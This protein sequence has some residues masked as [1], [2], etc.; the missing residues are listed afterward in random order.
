MTVDAQRVVAIMEELTEKLTY[1]SVVTRQ[2]VMVKR[3]KMTV[4]EERAR[5][6]LLERY[7]QQEKAAS[8]RRTELEKQLTL[9]RTEREK[10]SN[11]SCETVVKLK[12][13]LQ[14]VHDFTEQRLAQ[15]HEQYRK[16][17]AEHTRNF[18]VR[19]SELVARMNQQQKHN[20][21]VFSRGKQETDT[22]KS[23]TKIAEKDLERIIETYDREMMEKNAKAREVAEANATK[24][25]LVVNL[26]KQLQVIN[27][28]ND[29]IRQEY[30]IEKVR[31]SIIDRQLQ[32]LAAAATLLQA[33]WRG[34]RQREEY[35]AMKKNARNKRGWKGKKN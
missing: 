29:R 4:E 34:I 12:A 24:E 7:I 3:M 22:L 8:S 27:E 5:K 10:A 28:E 20:S 1:L 33:Y 14:D 18:D 13:D 25:E 23:K 26:Q 32:R 21:M 35:V 15:L 6:E 19:A 31:Q 9:L 30:E 16:R 17:E 11:R 2:D